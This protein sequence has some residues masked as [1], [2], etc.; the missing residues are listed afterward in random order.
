MSNKNNGEEKMFKTKESVGTTVL[1]PNLIL[2]TDWN[3][4]FDYPTLGTLRKLVFN[5]E[6]NGFHKV[7]RR[8]KSR[9][10]I[11]VQEFFNWVDET[12]GILSTEQN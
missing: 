10:L 8:I 5:E 4:Y 2:L 12:N 7:I 6:T 3:N 11:N 9:I 1:V